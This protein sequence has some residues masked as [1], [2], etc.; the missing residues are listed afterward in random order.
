MGK[1]HNTLDYKYFHKT[2]YIKE[3]EKIFEIDNFKKEYQKQFDIMYD[4]FK[5][6]I[7]LN[8]ILFSDSSRNKDDKIFELQVELEKCLYGDLDN[9]GNKYK[10]SV[11]TIN[12]LLDK[13]TRYL[14]KKFIEWYEYL[15]SISKL[16]NIQDEIDEEMNKLKDIN[17][18][19]IISSN[20]N[21]KKDKNSNKSY[22][23]SKFFKYNLDKKYLEQYLDDYYDTYVDDI[24]RNELS[25]EVCLI[26]NLVAY[27]NNGI[28]K[29]MTIK[30]KMTDINE[31]EFDYSYERDNVEFFEMYFNGYL[32][33]KFNDIDFKKN[34]DE[35]QQDLLKITIFFNL[36]NYKEFNLGKINE[37]VI[38]QN[39]DLYYF[40]MNIYKISK[41]RIKL[42]N[43]NNMLLKIVERL[44]KVFELIKSHQFEEALKIVDS[45]IQ[46]NK[47]MYIIIS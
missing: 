31:I 11:R 17:F 24:D 16:E 45:I 46:K 4:I 28:I 3:L 38:L 29:E 26:Y 37:V 21:Y 41:N 14:F 35:F 8:N 10:Y 32:H 25:K 42:N 2:K 40:I 30:D 13:H 19:Y 27:A 15:T 22:C 9:D 12:D 39:Y 6:L 34:A 36:T 18:D 7:I 20:I 43:Q 5:T 33:L 1:R 44:E 47:E 23:I